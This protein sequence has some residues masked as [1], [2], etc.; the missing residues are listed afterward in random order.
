[1][2][3][4]IYN[5][6]LNIVIA[7]LGIIIF[8]I[9]ISK[10][11]YINNIVPSINDL[12]NAI[13]RILT[14]LNSYIMILKLLLEVSIVIV[15]SLGISIILI[16]FSMINK[17]I[18]SVIKIYISI[19]KVIPL[20]SLILILFIMFFP[21]K[22]RFF[23][24]MVVVAIVSIPICFETLFDAIKQIDKD[25]IDETNTISK[26]TN[27]Q[28]YLKV[29]LPII[30]PTILTTIITTFGMGIKTLIMSEALFSVKSTIGEKINNSST[31]MMVDELYA[32]T[33]IV[34]IVLLFIDGI[35]RRIYNTVMKK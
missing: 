30:A 13:I 19:I 18:E 7:S 35:L 23:G 21:Q 6:A 33:I 16:Y 29:I 15:A 10:I 17:R 25:L 12:T 28:I 34:I 3:N 31:Y 24:A 27:I 14:T 2:K 4:S 9:V 22:I 11:E 26:V 8:C 5:K 32:W 1:M 20:L